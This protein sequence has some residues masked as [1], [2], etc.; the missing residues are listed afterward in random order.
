[1]TLVT[2][3]DLAYVDNKVGVPSALTAPFALLLEVVSSKKTTFPGR[4]DRFFGQGCRRHCTSCKKGQINCQDHKNT[5]ELSLVS[6]LL[7]TSIDVCLLPF[8][9][10]KFTQ[11]QLCT[12]TYPIDKNRSKT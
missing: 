10:R 11:L 6:G 2:R 3:V 12:S 7:I 9:L 4:R 8:K 5:A 1:M